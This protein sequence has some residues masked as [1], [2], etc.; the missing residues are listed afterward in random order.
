MRFGIRFPVMARVTRKDAKGEYRML[1][2]H[3]H[4]EDVPEVSTGETEVAVPPVEQVGPRGEKRALNELRLHD[5]RLY[6][7]LGKSGDRDAS[8]RMPDMFGKAFSRAGSKATDF[9][10]S[11]NPGYDAFA[12]AFPL[13]R[14]VHHLFEDRLAALSM[15]GSD[16]RNR[17]WPKTSYWIGNDKNETT[18]LEQALDHILSVNADDLEESFAMHRAQAGR[19]LVIDGGVWYET[20]PPCIEVD[21]RW[22]EYKASQSTVFLRYRYMPETMEQQPTS[23]F[24]PISAAEQ[25]GDLAHRLCKRFRMEGVSPL[26]HGF[27]TSDHPSFDFDSNEDIVTRTGQ[28]LAS[29]VLKHAVQRP[30]KVKHVDAGW[31]A[32]ISDML[33]W[34]NHLIGRDVDYAA[35]LPGLVDQFLSLAPVKSRGMDT[36]NMQQLKKTLPLV[37][38]MMDDLPISLHGLA[39]TPS[40]TR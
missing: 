15:D 28:A 18:L 25:A 14:P 37:V 26:R 29:N 3:V 34:H 5:D 2:S 38:E 40:N 1:V 20:R 27:E 16:S 39:S 19:L 24:F 13:S 36:L 7:Y 22:A 8:S 9:V 17:T 10:A 23:I 12:N 30:D 6:R 11:S 35:E 32:R 4:V 31:I 33:H 21:T